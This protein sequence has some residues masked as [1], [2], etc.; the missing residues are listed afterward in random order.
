VN[1]DIRLNVSFWDHWK[2]VTLKAELGLEAIE[3]LQ[4]LWCFAAQNK[5]DGILTRMSLK[6]VELSAKWNGIPGQFVSKL[7]E[8][9]FLDFDGKTY[10]LHDWA[11]HN[12]YCAHAKDRKEQARKTA[13]VS[14][15]NRMSNADSKAERNAL[16][17]AD[18]KAERNAPSPSPTPS[19]KEEKK[20]L[21]ASD[22]AARANGGRF[23]LTRKKRKLTGILLENFNRF[24]DSFAYQKNKAEAADV[25]I[26]L[27]NSR[28]S[29]ITPDVV[30]AIVAGAL[31]EAS[32]RQETIAKGLTPKMAP[33]WLYS[34]RWED[35]AVEDWVTRKERELAASGNEVVH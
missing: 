31:R 9:D 16:S 22:D 14:W 35:E 18:S 4:R 29:P 1:K 7:V 8:L 24:W 32:S 3:S 23:Y 19:P 26:D 10:S 34:R 15:K 5:T 21:S 33:G 20:I 17:N 11:D 28:A 6:A 12:G 13:D 30:E 27:S 25:W 2:T